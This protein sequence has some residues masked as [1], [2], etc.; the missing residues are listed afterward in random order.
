MM[1]TY[2]PH[3]YSILLLIYGFVRLIGVTF[4]VSG[5]LVWEEILLGILVICTILLLIISDRTNSHPRTDQWTGFYIW[6]G[7]IGVM[8]VSMI[9][10]PLEIGWS[11]WAIPIIFLLLMTLFYG[12]YTHQ[13]RI[14]QTEVFE[15][16]GY[17]EVRKILALKVLSF[18]M[19]FFVLLLWLH[20]GAFGLFLSSI[21][22]YEITIFI[23]IVTLLGALF[24]AV[25]PYWKWRM[26]EKIETKHTLIDE[27][28]HFTKDKIWKY[29][30]SICWIFL[31]IMFLIRLF[32]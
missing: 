1:R 31:L 4:K 7:V 6:F 3:V 11:Q 13:D 27:I 22:S 12:V 26:E 9:I 30:S 24:I 21:L 8:G 32:F 5:L 2:L 20:L 10:S 15:R 19:W 29:L 14:Y 17:M 23:V 28:P 25:Y 16:K 18:S